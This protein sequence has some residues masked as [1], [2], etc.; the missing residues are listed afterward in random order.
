MPGKQI[1]FHWKLRDMFLPRFHGERGSS[2]I[3]HTVPVESKELDVKSMFFDSLDELDPL[4]IFDIPSQLRHVCCCR[5]TIRNN[6]PWLNKEV[7]VVRLCEWNGIRVRFDEDGVLGNHNRTR[8]WSSDRFF[9]NLGVVTPLLGQGRSVSPSW[10][11]LRNWRVDLWEVPEGT[12]PSRYFGTTAM[13]TR[14]KILIGLRKTH[15][16]AG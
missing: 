15:Y 9:W 11:L 7:V 6:N 3:E 4:D 1:G 8:K 5:L 14:L 13:A 2:T 10:S 12:D 16:A